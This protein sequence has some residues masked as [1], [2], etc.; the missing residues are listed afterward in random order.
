MRD[1]VERRIESWSRGHL[2]IAILIAPVLLALGMLAP[3]VAHAEFEQM[4]THFGVSGEAHQIEGATGMAIN[5][6]GAGGVQAGSFYLVGLNNRV[7]RFSAGAEGEEP[8]FEEA[9]GWGIA[10]G[11][12]SEAYVRCGPAYH[13]TA[14]P[15]NHTYEHCKPANPNAPFGGEQTGNFESPGGVAVDQAT[16]NVYVRNQNPPEGVHREHHLIEVFTASGVPVGEGFGDAGNPESVPPESIAEGPEKLHFMGL[17]ESSIAVDNAGT[18]YLPD[19]DYSGVAAPEARVMRFEPC[20]AGDYENYCYSA[21]QDIVTLDAPRI[22][23]VGN[24]RLVVAN[25]EAIREY[26]LQAGHVTAI[27][28]LSVP[29]QLF[30]MTTNQL[31]G[32]VF[33]YTLADHSIH[34]RA[35][36]NE[37]TG[38]FPEIQKIKPQPAPQ[39]IRGL[40]INQTSAWG[41]SRPAGILYAADIQNGLGDIFAPA[42]VFSPTVETESTAN[43]TAGSTT[44][45]A[46]INPRGF[47]VSFYFEYLTESEYVAN[48]NSFEGANV[49]ARVPASN[50]QLA[51]GTPSTVTASVSDLVSSTA[52]RF[53]VV[54]S[55]E[56]AGAGQPLCVTKGGAERFATYP[57]SAAGLPDGRAYELVSPAEKH[58]GEVFPAAPSV[59]SCEGECKPPGGTKAQVFPMQSAPDGNT[60]AYMGFP[61]SPTVGAA[62][63]NSFVSRRSA[64]GWQTTAASP[65]LLSRLSGEHLTYGSSLTS[66]LIRQTNPQLAPQAPA[67]YENL[68]LEDVAAPTTLVPLLGTPPPHRAAGPFLIEY[69]GASPDF[70]AQ[71]FAANDSLTSATAYAPEPS[72]PGATGRDLYEWR[73]GHLALVNVLPGNLAVASGAGFASASPDAHAVSENGR[74]VFWHVGSI[75]YARE[76][77]QI[78]RQLNHSGTFLTASS[79]GLQVLFADGCLYSLLTETCTDLTQGEGA[80]TFQGIAGQSTDLARIYFIDTAKLPVSGPNERHEEAQVGKPNLYLYEAGAGTRF[81]ASLLPADNSGNNP[82]AL[83]DWTSNSYERTAEASPDGRYLAFGST[84]QLTGYD[85]VGPCGAELGHIIDIPCNE[86][87]LYDS[88][89]GRL[90]CA[91]CNPTGEAPLGRTTLR[92]IEGERAWQ[93]QPRYLTNSGRLFFDSQDRLTPRDTNGRVEDVYEAES[94][95][96]GSCARPAGCISLISPGSGS[97]DANF[98]AMDESGANVF[99]TTRE[100]LVPTDSDELVD[101]YDA[102]EG[103]GFSTES[104]LQLGQCQGEACQPVPSQ[105]VVSS[106]SS[107]AFNGPGNIEEKKA[108]KC[109]KGKVKKSGKCVKK[110]KKG[111]AKQSQK[112]TASGQP[113]GAK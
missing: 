10:E 1:A 12:P 4:P 89:T 65:S 38:Q 82:G 80:S 6:S 69:S 70:S 27:C 96:V 13:L 100:R 9:W 21:G 16:G 110:K 66:G 32:E 19:A 17:A 49:P 31:T 81:I 11:G 25:S 58:S 29:G 2:G 105:P 103:G 55:S 67:G 52:Y 77:G 84:G 51:S 37:S 46:K 83:N 92:R 35:A 86:A 54:A 28:A 75:V 104:E 107:Q 41:P 93:P 34:R 60:V 36:C 57:L 50:G 78:T 106:P 33:Y 3:G 64:T 18:V 26:P 42:E 47:A 5:V 43:T 101:L 14:N 109:P 108:P 85:N 56:C 40:A 79:D 53:R 30:A 15:A 76:D 61:F 111:H 44:L 62:V 72:D 24:S 59:G 99:F 8:R 98:L 102:R 39:K 23:L 90:D 113:G 20:S 97:V 87:F 88:A 112:R 73:G 71:F 63:W 22:S 68:Y 95:N 91:S 45:Q 48:G 7:V 74:R 94:D